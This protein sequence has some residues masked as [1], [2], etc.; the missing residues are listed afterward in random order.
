MAVRLSR[1]RRRGRLLAIAAILAGMALPGAGVA[2]DKKPVQGGTLILAL[3]ADAPTVNPDVSTG[4]PDQLIGCSVYEGLTQ[5]T[6]GIRIQ[7][8]L[9][10]SWT[11]SPDGLTYD[12][13]LNAAKW[14]DGKPFRSEDVRYS[15]LEVSSKFSSLFAPAGRM[16]DSIETP[17]PDRVVLKLKQPFGPLLLSLACSGG[18]AIMPAHIFK[19]TNIPSN[20]ASTSAPVGTGPFKLTE[21]K[22]GDFIRLTRNPDYWNAGR[23]YLNEVIAKVIPQ[24]AARMQALQAGEVDFIPGYYFSL[25]NHA[26]VR[27]DRRLKL[28]TSGFPPGS[29]FLFFNVTKKPLDDLRVRQALFVGTNREFLVRT[30]WSGDGRPAL[31]PFNDSIAWAANPDIDYSK[32][33]GFDPKRA[34]QMLDDAG[35]KRDAKGV[36]FTLRF[37][38]NSDSVE[39]G[40]AALAVKSMWKDIGVDVV[41]EPNERAT[42]VKRVY[43]DRDFDVAAELYTSYGDPALGFARTFV[44]SAIG[45]PYGNPSGYSNSEID[46]LFDKGE[47]ATDPEARGK[48][49]HAAQAILA[50]DLP[51]LTIRDY[52]TV[53]VA[54]VKLHGA[55]DLLGPAS[56]GSAW[57]EK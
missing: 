35:F 45:R 6:E 32:M 49:Y 7:P 24:P 56:L 33:Y 29:A 23:P 18:G 12:F 25:S 1:F 50:R 14:Q 28:V 34:N 10:K 42:G 31:R 47:K 16:I 40:Q 41:V 30:A 17:A 54:T 43:Q 2:Q 22:R 44:S 4:I 53:D 55:W 21:W 5:V 27:S 8:L 46:A 26:I 9:A 13:Q 39:F 51:D 19:D 11:I 3:G 52:R 15:I 37:A 57:L 36:R 48:H 38:Y 20:P